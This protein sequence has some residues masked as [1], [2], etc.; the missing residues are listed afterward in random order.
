MQP[1]INGLRRK[2]TYDEVLTGIL[3]EK[4]PFYYPD[5]TATRLVKSHEFGQ[6]LGESFNQLQQQELREMKHRQFESVLKEMARNGDYSYDELRASHMTPPPIPRDV[7][8]SNMSDNDPMEEEVLPEE[9]TRDFRDIFTQAAPQRY[10]PEQMAA[11]AAASTQQELLQHHLYQKGTTSA[12]AAAS[13]LERQI[14]LENQRKILEERARLLE[15]ERLR[16]EQAN[17]EFERNKREYQ[18]QLLEEAQRVEKA[19]AVAEQQYQAAQVELQRQESSNKAEAEHLKRQGKKMERGK[20][21]ETPSRE[22]T[23]K[24][25]KSDKT[26]GEGVRRELDFSGAAASSSLPIGQRESSPE[27]LREKRK[28]G[29]PKGSTNIK[30]QEPQKQERVVHGTKIEQHTESEWFSNYQSRGYLVDQIELRGIPL[31][32]TDM[33]NMGLKRLTKLIIE[34]DKKK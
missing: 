21:E 16:Q 23:K 9:P 4:Q 19:K 28:P 30:K 34:Y 2:P 7:F 15:Q 12:A 8:Q 25:S 22:E 17:L 3:R 26:E 6:L 33:K 29:R 31:T 11:A 27:T 10:P 13:D 14:E 20:P 32:N 1:V 24:K 18:Q 5:R